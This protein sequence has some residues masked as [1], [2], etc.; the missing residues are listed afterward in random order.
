MKRR[1]ASVL[2]KLILLGAMAWIVLGTTGCDNAQVY[3]GVT[4]AGPYGH[5]PHGYPYGGA[6]GG[7]AVY[8]RPYHR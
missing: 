8:G 3:M 4:V 7:V 5:Y 1:P 6:R 2:C